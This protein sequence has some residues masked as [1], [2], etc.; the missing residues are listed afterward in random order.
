MG[1]VLP[2]AL[3]KIEHEYL[4][5]GAAGLVCLVVFVGLILKPALESYG[6]IWEKAAASVLSLFVLAVLI[7]IGVVV[8]LVIVV[9][10]NSIVEFL[11]IK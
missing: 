4:L 7:A 3:Q 11:H 1:T 6:R 2:F 10:Y 8:G 9:D 5:F